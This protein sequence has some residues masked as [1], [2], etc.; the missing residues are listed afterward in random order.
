MG[1]K[2][3]T[4]T[5][6]AGRYTF[7]WP[8]LGIMAWVDQ[9]KEHSDSRTTCRLKI[10]SATR[11]QLHL[12]QFNLAAIR[13]R[14]DLA[15]AL[16]RRHPLDEDTYPWDKV[17]EELCQ[18]IL[19][20][21]Q[22]RPEIHVL[23]PTEIIDPEYLVYPLVMRRDIT[24]WYGPGSA[25]KSLTAMYIALIVQNGLEFNGVPVE[26]MNVLY[27]DWETDRETAERRATLLARPLGVPDPELPKY[28]KCVLPLIDDMA[29]IAIDMIDHD[30][31]FVIV[32]SGGP[33][34]A[35]D[36]QSPELT[37]RF[38]NALR[39]I[40]HETGA[41]PLVLTHVT[42][43][44]RRHGGKWLPIG[45]IYWENIPRIT[46][47][48]RRDQQDEETLTIGL[49]NRKINDAFPHRPVGLRYIFADRGIL[50]ESVR[51][52]DKYDEERTQEEMVLELLAGGA[53]TVK[54]VAR[55]LEMN[56]T[57][58][59]VIL[60]RLKHKKKVTSFRKENQYFWGL[61]AL[62]ED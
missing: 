44:E 29:D 58:A 22:R 55:Y 60:N 53:K 32:D 18:E 33:A 28:R 16:Q 11:G 39:R 62:N 37:L 48:L 52:E 40:C 8:E 42:K 12:G 50:V 13:S 45:C 1:R 9:I 4:V 47:E 20:Q 57:Q 5:V 2:P 7:Q 31:G 23:E 25:G 27:L 41:T 54:E 59:R 34:C 36:V 56:P 21:E 30:I 43:A 61:L 6:K 46:W 14:V 15:K 26:K 10:M 38:F 19:T 24:L 49:Y 51:V 3:Y 17:I 35:G